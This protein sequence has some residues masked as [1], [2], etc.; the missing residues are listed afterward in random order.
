MTLGSIIVR[1][2]MNT[3]DF[4]TDAKRAAKIAEQRAKQIDASFRKAGIAIGVALGAGL[5]V[6]GAAF[7]K[8]VQNTIEAEKVQAQ[9]AARIKDTAGAAG[10]SMTQ[11]NDQAEKLQSMTIFD[12]EAIGEAQAML[13]TFKQIGGVQFDRTIESA[14]D[15]ATAMG[16]DATSA[17]KVLGRALSDPEKGM[18]ALSRAGVVFTETERERIKAMAEAGRVTEAQTAILDKLQGSMGT[19]AEAARNTLGGALQ[20]LQNAFDNL[21]EGDT[22]DAG[23]RGTVDGVNDLIDTLNDPGVKSGVDSVATGLLRITEAAI[24]AVSWIGNASSALAEFYGQTSKQ[25]QNMLQNRRV[26]LES[27]LF[28]EQRGQKRSWLGAA[29]VE[30]APRVKELKAEIAA[31][32]ARLK[33]LS[34]AGRTAGR[35]GFTSEYE[36][37]SLNFNPN[38]SGGGGGAAPSGRGARASGGSKSARSMPD[39]G[40]EDLENLQRMVAETSAADEALQRMAATLSGPLAEAEFEHQ[41]NLQRMTELGIEAG[42]STSEIDALKKAET[43]RYNEQRQAIEATLNPME[44]LLAAQQAEFGMLGLGNTEREMMNALR[45]Q[46]I[47]L[48]GDEARA[49]MANAKA[50]DKQIKG[51]GLQLEAMDAFRREGSDFLQALAGGAKPVDAL[52]EALDGLAAKLRQMIA[53]N[54]MD[55]FFGPQGS[56][57]A[58]TSGGGWLGAL[59]GAIFGGGG[60]YSYSSGGVTGADV[61]G[62]FDDFMGGWA[63]GGWTGPG[64]MN[65]IRGPAHADEIIWSKGD[66]ARAGGVGQ[67]E[68]ARRGGG[69]ARGGMTINQTIT[70]PANTS[71]DTAQQAGQLAYAGAGRAARRNG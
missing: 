24:K 10:R 54:L 69:F 71:Y 63:R 55:Q 12:D 40:R 30:N 56:T 5:A 16:T 9:L 28:A 65:E 66:V 1:L 67:V 8:Y 7:R 20:A 61:A 31:I 33:E 47:D 3:A 18:S 34:N 42:R 2:T 19:A 53:D 44:Q 57:G 13:L 70:V 38:G 41:Q 23:L 52:T 17:A 48:L 21:L 64:G 39:F 32:D 27:E 68:A 26:D 6:A 36:R 4:D 11:L 25:S 59:V 45:A 15:L 50:M 62:V 43:E 58:G 46:G 22:G 49:Y 35:S 51:Q 37:A 14:L 29:A 60:G